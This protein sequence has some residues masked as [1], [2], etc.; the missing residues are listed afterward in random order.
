MKSIETKLK[1]TWNQLKVSWNQSKSI[2]EI[3]YNFIQT[4]SLKIHIKETRRIVW[5][6]PY[7][8]QDPTLIK[9]PVIN[10]VIGNPLEMVVSIGKS[11]IKSV[12][13][14]CNV[15]L[16]EGICQLSLS[17]WGPTTFV[18]IS[19]MISHDIPTTITKSHPDGSFI[20]VFFHH[21]NHY[22]LLI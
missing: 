18:Y 14:H 12:F 7:T 9:F 6:G 4:R 10:V 5:G 21:V 19:H 8:D 22:N 15:W 13:V 1:I 2:D 20:T 17:S 11:P 3:W 16:P